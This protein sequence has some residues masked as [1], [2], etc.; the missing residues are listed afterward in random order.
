[1]E[2]CNDEYFVTVQKLLL[3]SIKESS[4]NVYCSLFEIMQIWNFMKP[5]TKK[6]RT[7]AAG[8]L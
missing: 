3:S 5:A 6:K 4:I 8:L 7:V 2:T 1:M